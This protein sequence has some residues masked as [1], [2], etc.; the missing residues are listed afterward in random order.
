MV[1][2]KALK[3]ITMKTLVFVTILMMNCL[4][5]EAGSAG[6]TAGAQAEA[7]SWN[8]EPV[9]LATHNCLSDTGESLNVT[10]IQARPAQV[11]AVVTNVDTTMEKFTGWQ[12]VELPFTYGLTSEQ[13]GKE[14]VLSFSYPKNYGGR[15][16]RCGPGSGDQT[17][18]AKLQIDVQEINF[19][20]PILTRN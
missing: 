15:C 19:T 17:Y 4:A 10:V 2:D 3:G 14:A 11:T 16:G 20:C 12:L 8:Q 5:A 9:V 1:S 18:Y 7:V 6:A 13:T